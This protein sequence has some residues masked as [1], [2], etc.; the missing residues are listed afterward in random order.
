MKTYICKHCG[1]EYKPKAKDRITYCSRECSFADKKAKPK[2][3]KEKLI[4]TCVVC[5]KQF[6][7]RK[8]SKLCN[9]DKCR[10]EYNNI[11]YH[12]NAIIKHDKNASAIHCKECGKLFAPSYGCKRRSFCSDKCS[13]KYGRKQG[14]H[15]RRSILK[16]VEHINYSDLNIF[17]RDKWMCQLCGKKVNPKYIG[18]HPM[19]PS[20]DHIIPISLGGSDTPNNVQLAHRECNRIKSNGLYN[21]TPEQLIL[22]G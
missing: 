5:G 17:K 3:P 19:A 21:K 2:E 10:K 9:G 15:K 11:K 12:E 6:E 14:K 16:Q 7:G 18:N 8:N 20:I 13:K 1:K 4:C 22:F